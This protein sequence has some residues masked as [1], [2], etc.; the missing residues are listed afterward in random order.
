M[1]S[2]S[3]NVHENPLIICRVVHS[4]KGQTDRRVDDNVRIS[5]SFILVMRASFH[6]S[7]FY[8]NMLFNFYFPII[9]ELI[10]F[11]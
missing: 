4:A 2:P 1:N 11:T 3:V 7:R 8:W 5:E 10:Y 6:H 9:Y